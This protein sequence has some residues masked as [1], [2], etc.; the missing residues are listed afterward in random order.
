[1]AL[2]SSKGQLD[3]RTIAVLS[4]RVAVGTEEM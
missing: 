1:M 2:Q 3:G 4:D